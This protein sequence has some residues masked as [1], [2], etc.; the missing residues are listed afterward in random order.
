MFEDLENG[1][2]YAS[3]LLH[4][5]RDLP[6]CQQRPRI[7][8]ARY[9]G[10]RRPFGPLPKRRDECVS[11]VVVKHVDAIRLDLVDALPETLVAGIERR[12]APP[13]AQGANFRRA[14]PAVLYTQA[15]TCNRLS[16]VCEALGD[17]LARGRNSSS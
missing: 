9:G 4:G 14:E 1:S 7:Y 6:W 17:L 3:T 10:V 16:T 13:L 2:P 5:T 12:S 15:G 11:F 8:R